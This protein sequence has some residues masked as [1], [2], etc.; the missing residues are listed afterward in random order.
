VVLLYIDNIPRMLPQPC[1][2]AGT[3]HVTLHSVTSPECYH[4][5]VTALALIML[6]YIQ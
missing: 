6:L 3:D 1:Y 5:H 4:S 2:C